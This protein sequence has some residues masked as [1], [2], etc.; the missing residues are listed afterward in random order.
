MSAGR[1]GLWRGG[2]PLLLASTSATRRGLLESAG[3]PV[4]TQSPGVDE[5]ALERE[6]GAADPATI[7]AR[8]ARAKAEA[9]ARRHPGRVVLGADQVLDLDGAAL[10]KPADR[11]AALHQ[12]AR[13]AGRAHRLHSAFALAVNGAVVHEGLDGARLLMRPLG[14]EALALYLDLVGDEVWASVGVYRIEGLGLHL[15]EQ[16]EG[17]HATILGLPLL[18]VLAALRDRG[19]LAF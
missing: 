15:F 5:R 2:K 1:T 19:L 3:L 17:Q 4:E 8:L 18:P 16:V 11:A 9:V 12:L 7:A 13:L 6:F 10:S 14:P